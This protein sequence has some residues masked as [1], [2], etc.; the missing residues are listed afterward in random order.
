MTPTVA[1][2]AADWLAAGTDPLCVSHGSEGGP[3][4]V[5]HSVERRYQPAGVAFL[6]F[7]DD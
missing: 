1:E 3:A 5:R 6:R 7:L 4:Y 2:V